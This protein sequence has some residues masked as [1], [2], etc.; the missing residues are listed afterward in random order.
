MEDDAVDVSQHLKC[1]RFECSLAYSFLAR[2]R[3]GVAIWMRSG[4]EIE[5]VCG[6]STSHK[7][8]NY[9]VRQEA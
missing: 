2:I 5:T 7:L 8:G 9:K 6:G 1:G 4:G 3:I